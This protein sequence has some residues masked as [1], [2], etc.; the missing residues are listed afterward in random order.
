MLWFRCSYYCVREH[1][2]LLLCPENSSNEPRQTLTDL[3]VLVLESLSLCV[4]PLPH[5]VLET[6]KTPL[7]ATPLLGSDTDTCPPITLYPTPDTPY[8]IPHIRYPITLYPTPDYPIS[9][10]L[11]PISYSLTTRYLISYSLTTSPRVGDV[12]TARV[13]RDLQ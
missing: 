7:G 3:G 9:Y 12:S 8:P 1:G 10:S 6:L 2:A 13:P 11:T 4:L 5:P